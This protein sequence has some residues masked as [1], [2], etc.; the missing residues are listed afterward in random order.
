VAG[1]VL[2]GLLMSFTPGALLAARPSSPAVVREFKFQGNKVF[3]ESQLQGVLSAY[4]R[5]KL[6]DAQIEQARIKVSR[7]YIDHGYTN[8][9]ALLKGRDLKAGIV[10]FQIVEGK[11]GTIHVVGNRWIGSSYIKSRLSR[12]GADDPYNANQTADNIAT[13]RREDLNESILGLDA[14]LEP[15]N[16]LGHSVLDVN[17]K[18]Q[19]PFR[20]SLIYDNRRPAGVGAQEISLLAQD[21]NLTGDNDPLEVDYVIAR[22]TR[23]SFGFS[24]GDN[25]AVT[26]TRPITSSDTTLSLHYSRA[27]FTV[28]EAPFQNL[29]IESNEDIYSIALRQPL[30]ERKNLDLGV[31]I[32]VDREESHTSL[33]G[34]PFTLA[35]GASNGT[36]DLTVFRFVQDF[37]LQRDADV[38]ALHQAFRRHRGQ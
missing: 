12:G 13:I 5:R 35:P 10:Y 36:A 37:S 9:G 30:I 28:I 6:S 27:D 23:N 17:V 26:Y 31:A 38:L 8:S 24:G 32:Q 11:V 7:Y 22:Q 25:L 33:L 3:S 15:G 4:T 2:L 29:D 19:Q 21:V 18:D 20:A 34:V 16:E 1:I 14:D